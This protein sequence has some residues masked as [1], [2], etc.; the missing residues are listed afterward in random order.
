M[1]VFFLLSID[2]KSLLQGFT[3]ST[4]FL[5]PWC[6][7]YN[8]YELFISKICFE[9]DAFRQIEDSVMVVLPCGNINLLHC[10][11]FCSV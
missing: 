4:M 8:L 11:T 6:F 7:I 5:L 10:I 9:N 2:H 1:H 3:D